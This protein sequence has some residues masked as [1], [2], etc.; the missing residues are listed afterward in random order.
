MPRLKLTK[1]ERLE[2]SLTAAAKILNKLMHVPAAK[3]NVM[4]NAD[5]EAPVG[6]RELTRG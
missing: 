2:Q 1:E 4:A 5:H 6:L 3:R